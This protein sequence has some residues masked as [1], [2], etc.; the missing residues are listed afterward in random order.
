[1]KND[2]ASMSVID[3]ESR[4]GTRMGKSGLGMFEAYRNLRSRTHQHD[5]DLD[6]NKHELTA[7]PAIHIYLY[8]L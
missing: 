2:L 3:I 8:M 1:M 4:Q 6:R 7:V 5:D